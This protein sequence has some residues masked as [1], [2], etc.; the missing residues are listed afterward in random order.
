MDPVLTDG[1]TAEVDKVASDSADTPAEPATSGGFDIQAFEA[2]RSIVTRQAERLEELKKDL[3]L[4][5]EQLKNILENDKELAVAQE[6]AKQSSQKFR[7]RKNQLL[8]MPEART[9]KLKQADLK[10][11]K[12]D[13]EDSISNHLFDL[14]QTTGVMEFEDLNGNVWEFDIRARLKTK[15]SG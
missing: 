8:E 1:Q 13:L 5:T 14:Y 10:E 3:K 9:M 7:Q 4:V 12:G 6:E 15:K 11:E 2:T